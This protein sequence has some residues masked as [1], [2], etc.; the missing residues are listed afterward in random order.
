MR[1][2]RSRRYWRTGGRAWGRCSAGRGTALHRPSGF[3]DAARRVL[4]GGVSA[5]RREPAAHARAAERR[6]VP[7]QGRRAQ[8]GRL[9]LLRPTR[10]CPSPHI[11]TRPTRLRPQDRGGGGGR[12]QR[13][14][15]LPARGAL[16]LA[17]PAG[18]EAQARLH[19]R[20]Q[21]S[22][23]AVPAAH[24]T[25]CVWRRA[26]VAASARIAASAGP[27]PATCFAARQPDSWVVRSRRNLAG[28]A[29]GTCASQL[30][31]CTCAG[32]T[33]IPVAIDSEDLGQT[34]HTVALFPGTV[35]AGVVAAQ[36]LA[37]KLRA[38]GLNV[39]FDQRKFGRVHAEVIAEPYLVRWR[40]TRL[41]ARMGLC[42][43]CGCA[44][45]FGQR[46]G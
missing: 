33:I 43:P 40:G 19:A 17:H 3:R 26:R 1:R 31:A 23:Q 34:I 35:P 20:T 27:D 39:Y 37:A 11:H 30:H 14:R 38:G 21:D 44:V 25:R 45:L 2:T 10:C 6:G 32:A 41:A 24:G 15:H 13:H 28:W 22:L 12:L 36:Q 4:V 18:R 7:A 29:H 46:R 42:R 8:S 16:L 5:G 9:R